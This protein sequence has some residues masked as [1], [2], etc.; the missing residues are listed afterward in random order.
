MLE[1]WCRTPIRLEIEPEGIQESG[2][3]YPTVIV[4]KKCNYQDKAKTVLTTEKKLVEITGSALF[5]GDICPELPVISGGTATIFGKSRRILQGSKA[6][7]PD[8]TVNY[9]EVL[10]I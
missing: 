10:L 9:T 4:E 8:G 3:P 1:S 2:E 5:P 7:N 6:R